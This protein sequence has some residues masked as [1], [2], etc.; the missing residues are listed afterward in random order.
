[1]RALKE[2]AQVNHTNACCNNE[3]S[4]NSELTAIAHTNGDRPIVHENI[5]NKKTENASHIADFQT[6]ISPLTTGCATECP[7]RV[8]IS[9]SQ[10]VSKKAVVRNRIKRQIKAA[11]RYLLPKVHNGWLLVIIVRPSAIQCDYWQFLRELEQML[12]RIEVID[13][14][15]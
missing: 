3:A 14:H 6:A 2:A 8:G 15:S 5:S 13:G 11:V 1:L 7:T 10:K 12:R 4:G 9:I